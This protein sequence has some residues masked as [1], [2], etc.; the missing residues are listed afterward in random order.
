MQDINDIVDYYD[1]Q[2]RRREANWHRCWACDNAMSD[3]SGYKILG[4]IYC[5]GC[6]FEAK[7]ALWDAMK[8]NLEVWVD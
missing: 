4:H 6:I 8:E 2:A 5:Q 7:E 1:A 3:E